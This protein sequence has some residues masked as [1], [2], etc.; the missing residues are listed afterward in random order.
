M[1]KFREVQV[2]IYL[3]KEDKPQ[4]TVGIFTPD[5]KLTYVTTSGPIEAS[6]KEFVKGAL[7]SSSEE[8]LFRNPP[9]FRE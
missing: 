9:L 8:W 5:G 2:R 1:I 3:R 6:V 4:V 7:E